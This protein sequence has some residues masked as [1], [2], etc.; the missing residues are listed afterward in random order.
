MTKKLTKLTQTQKDGL[1]KTTND[2]IKLVTSGETDEEAVKKAVNQ[3]YDNGG[4]PKPKVIIFLDSPIKCLQGR[5]YAAAYLNALT[6]SNAQVRDQVDAQVDAQVYAQV[7]AQVGDQVAAQVDAQVGA[8]VRAQVGAQVGDQNLWQYGTFSIW[9]SAWWLWRK[10][11]L[12][13]V[14]QASKADAIIDMWKAHASWVWMYPEITMVCRMPKIYR[15]EKGRLHSTEHGA[16]V[17]PDGYSLYF[18]HGVAF[19]EAEFENF[20]TGKTSAIEIMAEKNQDKKRVLA[21]CYGNEKLITE[22][23]AKVMSEETDDLGYQ[24]RILTIDRFNDEPM[25][26]YEAIDPAKNE[27]VYLRVPPE[28]K[29]KTPTEA[30]L[31]TFKELFELAPKLKKKIKFEQEA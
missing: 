18:L 3:I 8:Q 31:W 21:M 25:V 1:I 30:K 10:A 9:W 22:L 15:D 13:L 26:Y 6:K 17:Y 4:L 28:F 20:R 12:D 16:V 29:D 2:W 7:D 5:F 27:K 19:T 24:M 14:G 11:C 23:G